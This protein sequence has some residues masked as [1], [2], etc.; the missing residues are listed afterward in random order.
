MPASLP[1]DLNDSQLHGI[2]APATFSTTGSFTVALDNHGEA[3]HVHLHLDDDLS[4]AAR[5]DASNHYVD[6]ETARTVEIAVADIDEPATGKLKLVTGYGAETEYVEVMIEPPTEQ[7]DSVTVDES[8]N[9]PPTP[10]AE[11]TPV[12]QL[13]RRAGEAALPAL[14]LGAFAIVLSLAVGLF[15]DSLAVLLAASAVILG[16]VVAL[17]FLLR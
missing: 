5:L 8:L 2:D 1:I 4:R 10:T 11:P 16:V 6:A 14:A 13:Q 12:E 3:V 15:A 7:R 17:A 9:R